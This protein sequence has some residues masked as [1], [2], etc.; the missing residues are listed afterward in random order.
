M[1]MR[2]TLVSRPDDP[3]LGLPAIKEALRVDHDDEDDTILLYARSAQEHIEAMT[4]LSL[5]PQQ[6]E[7][8]FGGWPSRDA[9]SLLPSPVTAIEEFTYF[10]PQGTEQSFADWR[11]N[12]GG[13]FELTATPLPLLQEREDAVYIRLTAG[14]EA[15][16]VPE[17]LLTAYLMLVAHFYEHRS[18][19]DIMPGQ[20]GQIPFGVISLVRP[21]RVRGAQF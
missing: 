12:R 19:L 20:I 14:Y 3:L 4:G 6:W 7:R 13:T 1:G 2:T 10:D 9:I 17:G 21:H 16:K 5:Q 11:M 18:P 15:G 8:S